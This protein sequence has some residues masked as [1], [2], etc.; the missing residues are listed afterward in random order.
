MYKGPY[1]SSDV[2]LVGDVGR[3]LGDW[4]RHRNLDD[5]Q[6]GELIGYSGRTWSRRKN[7]P[8][9]ITIQE[10]WRIARALRIPAD[11]AVSAISSGL[12][13]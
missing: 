6:V 1:I 5:S 3:L 13:E 12:K 7:E 9:N 4:Q 2:R 10:F 8:E 11:T